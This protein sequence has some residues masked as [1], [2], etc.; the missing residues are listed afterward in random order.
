[1]ATKKN[2]KKKY[3]VTRSFNDTERT[4]MTKRINTYLRSLSNKR[5][6][7]IVTADDVHAYLTREGV[8]P[9]QIK[10]RLSFINSVLREPNFAA[11]DTVPSTRAAARGR[12]ITG[13]SA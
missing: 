6:S 8:T 11:V 10:T 3:I 13:W 2:I 4:S 7:G 1:M 9:K 5:S 12:M